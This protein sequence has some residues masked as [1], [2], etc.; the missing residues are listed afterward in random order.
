MDGGK[1]PSALAA[2][3]YCACPDSRNPPS[4]GRPGNKRNLQ[5]AEVCLLAFTDVFPAALLAFFK[6]TFPVLLFYHKIM[7]CFLT[8]PMLCDKHREQFIILL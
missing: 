7:N 5:T 8:F 1:G 4:Q 6:F 3:R 2:C